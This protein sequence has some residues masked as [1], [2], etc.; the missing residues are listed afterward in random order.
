[1]LTLN[2]ILHPTD[3]SE[4][5]GQALHHA[6]FL[7]RQHEATLHVLHVVETP[8]M[9]LYADIDALVETARERVRKHLE[10]GDTAGIRIE[11]K[12]AYAEK[13]RATILEQAQRVEAD[14]LVL[15]T[16]GREG[17]AHLLIGSTAE[18]VVR[19][20]ECPV[21]VVRGQEEPSP[22]GHV[23]HI[24]V[25]ID[26]SAH[27]RRAAA[28]AE[29]L[30]A[31]YGSRL[32]FLH[33]VE[34]LVPLPAYP[35]AGSQPA[36]SELSGLSHEIAE[37]AQHEEQKRVKEELER[38][39]RQAQE[40]GLDARYDLSIGSPPHPAGY[41]LD[42]VEEQGADLVVLASHGRTGLQRFFMGSVA[43]KVVQRA[44]CPILVV[45]SH[46]KQLVPEGT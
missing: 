12:V 45:K 43:E 31:G 24:L 1:M 8:P 33:A 10:T 2:N 14:L 15:G 30:A 41:I 22:P 4:S 38:L 20:A 28:H 35:G 37:Q 29:A 18:R 7:A 19:E 13:V 25:P 36:P 34:A 5:A 42:A 3:F 21:L 9:I 27:S 16:H 6:L 44:P 11:T 17:L 39:V 32:T 26:F 46:G 23:D 40:K